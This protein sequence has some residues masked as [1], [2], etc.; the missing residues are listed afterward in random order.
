[1]NWPSAT[2]FLYPR[3]KMK[4]KGCRFDTVEE[5]QEEMSNVLHIPFGVQRMEEPLGV[6]HVGDYFEEDG[7]H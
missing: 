7:G 3:I 2:I 6:L 1:M 4:L 5:I